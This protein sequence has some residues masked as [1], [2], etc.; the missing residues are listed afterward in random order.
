[1]TRS[2]PICRTLTNQAVNVTTP[3]VIERAKRGPIIR[4]AQ[5]M[6]LDSR[7][8]PLQETKFELAGAEELGSMVSIEQ[9]AFC[10]AG[11]LFSACQIKSNFPH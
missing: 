6:I 11:I 10:G 3:D 9:V 1:M 4:G 2:T 7:H 5:L 8:S